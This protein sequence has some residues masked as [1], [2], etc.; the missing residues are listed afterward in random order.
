MAIFAIF[1][2]AFLRA[3]L[4]DP[5]THKTGFQMLFWQDMTFSMATLNNSV[6]KMSWNFPFFNFLYFQGHFD[7]S[8]LSHFLEIIDEIFPGTF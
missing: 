7:K 2:G 3:P 6:T 5:E 1:W 4:Q 8:Y